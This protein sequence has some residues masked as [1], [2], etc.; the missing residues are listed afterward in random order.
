[1]PPRPTTTAAYTTTEPTTVEDITTVAYTT[2]EPTPA[3]DTTTVAY[4]TTEPT[5][6]EDTTAV[7]DTTTAA[8]DTTTFADSTTAPGSTVLPPNSPLSKTPLQFPILVD[9]YAPSCDEGKYL[10]RF[11]NPTP[12]NGKR[13]HAEVNKE[14]EIRI[15]AVATHSEI[16]DVII[17]G[18]LDI[19]K[20][21]TTHKVFVIRWTPDQDD[22]G[23]YFPI[24]FIAEGVSESRVYQSEMRCVLVEVEK[25]KVRA[26]V[27]CD[28]NKMT[29]KVEKSSLHG[30]D[31]DHLRLSDSSNTA[32]NLQSNSTHII[33]VVPLN[34][35]GTQIEEDDKNLIFR[36]EITSFENHHDIITRDDLVEINFY[37]QYAKRG[38][39]SL[40]FGAHR[41]IVEVT[42]KGF[43]TFSY[44]FEFYQT[45]HF[46]HKVESHVYPIDVEVRQ[47]IY[48]EIEAKSSQNNTELFVESCRAAPYDNPNYQPSYSIIENGCPVDKTV[49]IFSP[50]HARHF[51]FGMEAFRFIGLH[52]Q[53]YI[54]CS[55][56]LCEA[57]NPD[58]RC[59]QGCAK[60]V[61]SGPKGNWPDSG[62][63]GG[64]RRKREIAVETAR[65]HISQGPLRLRKNSV[66]NMNLNMNTVLMAGC[67]LAAVAM[68]CG[69]MLYKMKT[70]GV[71]YQPLSTF[72]S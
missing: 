18:P 15:R 54:S 7:T 1:P 43:G 9:S 33:G 26:S 38:N 19:S 23:Q 44:E 37:C 2:T 10:P 59:A 20:H 5:T 29:V 71:K 48:M 46:T 58:S 49:H 62:E 21:M 25:Q 24:C 64:H 14:L 47:R 70:S 52:D 51:Q 57:G 72:E 17:T 45:S 41:E 63:H 36:N 6:F 61:T 69:V 4:T 39:V 50:R 22:L 31:V 11:V 3:V 66:T 56:M 65:H 40:S 8:T 53:V 16:K 27:E 42:E 55:V 32:C 60:S 30:I 28:E 34:A 67:I 35:C 13:I 12:H 68:L